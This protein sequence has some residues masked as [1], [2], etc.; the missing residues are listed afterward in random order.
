MLQPLL[1]Y[2]GVD[3]I[4]N[5]NPDTSFLEELVTTYDLHELVE[6]D[7][8]E[9]T[10]QDK[11]DVY[12]QCL[13]IVLHFPKYNKSLSK[14]VSNE[15]NLILGKSYFTTLTTYQT[16]HISKLKKEF[17]AELGEAEADEQHKFSPYYLLYR[18]MDMMYD[19]TLR[20]LQA[21]T[22][23]LRSL[24]TEVFKTSRLNKST[25]EQIMVR[26]RNAV[27]IKHMFMPHQEIIESLQ[28]EV[29]KFFGGELDVYFEDLA[30]K[31]DKILNVVEILDEDIESLYDTYNAMVNMKTNRII[32][33]LT[34]FTAVTG[35]M[36][37][38][39]GIFGMNIPLP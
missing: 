3:R 10:T 21:F 8:L 36:T 9:P 27:V 11:I 20:A 7:I 22:K 18:M 4:Y 34:I 2:R 16:E 25:L 24:E 5:Y 12:D 13:F 31:I 37:L 14:Y 6:E 1:S 15:F 33:L 32:T 39:S 26:R 30:Y 19:K 17:E 35:V 28:D 23:D 38:I 29:Q